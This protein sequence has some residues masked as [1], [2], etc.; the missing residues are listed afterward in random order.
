MQMTLPCI[1]LTNLKP[2]LNMQQLQPAMH[3]LSEWC[4][5]N[6]MLINTTKTKVILITTPQ[7]QL[8]LNN[9]SLQ[10][11]YNNE[12]LSVVACEKILAVFMDNNLT[13]T[14]HQ[15]P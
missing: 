9:Y 4:K 12:A 6:G 3:K 14:N 1:I 13:W 7:K 15:Q 10:L 11:T 2:V 8:Y 5:E